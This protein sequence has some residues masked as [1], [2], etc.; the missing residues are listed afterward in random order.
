MSTLPPP[1]TARWWR[2]PGVR[3]RAAD[4]LYLAA[5][6]L[7]TVTEALD[8]DRLGGRAAVVLPVATCTLGTVALL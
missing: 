4:V 1:A 6:A 8:A 2:R 3:A 7:I 5:G